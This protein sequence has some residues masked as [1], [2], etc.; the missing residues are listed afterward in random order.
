MLQPRLPEL[1]QESSALYNICLTFQL[2]L[3]TTHTSQFF[4]YLDTSLREFRF[5]LASSTTLADGTLTAGL[6]LCSIGVS[7]LNSRFMTRFGLIG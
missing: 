1:C 5:E 4:E 3:S 7:D 6:L 2:S